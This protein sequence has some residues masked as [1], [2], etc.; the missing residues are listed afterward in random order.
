MRSK[1][2]ITLVLLIAVV[3]VIAYFAYSSKQRNQTTPTSATQMEQQNA[4]WQDE[5]V[6]EIGLTLQHPK[7]LVFRKEIADDNGRI[8]TVGFFLTKGS[9]NSPEYQMY[10]LYQQFKDGSQQDLELAKKEMDS[11][12][13]KEASITGY[14]GIE[15][16]I[17]GPKTRFITTVIKDGKLFSV[18]TIPPTEENKELTEQIIATFDFE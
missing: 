15:G 6:N 17:I 8:R 1:Q 10:G 3:A 7:D 18:S 5:T 12:T 11:T 14:S 16:L 9:E 13:I 2:L 4:D